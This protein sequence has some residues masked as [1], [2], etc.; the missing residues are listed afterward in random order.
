MGL[1]PLGD[2][3]SHYQAGDT[4]HLCRVRQGAQRSPPTPPGPL[5]GRRESSL[6]HPAPL[7]K[8]PRFTLIC[9]KEKIQTAEAKLENEHGKG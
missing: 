1:G 8:A 3:P 6:E 9:Q 5:R 2:K 7:V 4:W